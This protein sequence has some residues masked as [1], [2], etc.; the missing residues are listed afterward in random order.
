M[1]SGSP[2]R[3]RHWDRAQ[4]PGLSPEQH[5]NASE[6]ISG[7]RRVVVIGLHGQIVTPASIDPGIEWE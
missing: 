3:I 4:T 1:T 6:L 5:G 7:R 2:V